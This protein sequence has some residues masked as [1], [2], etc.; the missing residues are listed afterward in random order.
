MRHVFLLLSIF[1]FGSFSAVTTNAEEL[2][3]QIMDQLDTWRLK[4]GID[5]F[6]SATDVTVNGQLM[7]FS[8]T[9]DT[10][11]NSLVLGLSSPRDKI[12]FMNLSYDYSVMYKSVKSNKQDD[13]VSL[14]VHDIGTWSETKT[15]ILSPKIYYPWSSTVDY[16]IDLNLGLGLGLIKSKGVGKVIEDGV[17]ISDEISWD[18]DYI[19]GYAPSAGINYSYFFSEKSTVSMDVSVDTMFSKTDDFSADYYS[20]G[21]QIYFMYLFSK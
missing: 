3:S 11:E 19:I 7:N 6:N 1:V 18:K 2:N 4:V 12:D 16:S 13:P 8:G 17:V 20:F 10:A 5:H 9:A 14:E 15:I 21:V